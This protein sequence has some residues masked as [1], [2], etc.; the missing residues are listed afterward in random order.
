MYVTCRTP[1]RRPAAR[2]LIEATKTKPIGRAVSSGE[3]NELGEFL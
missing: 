2:L 1:W 3:R